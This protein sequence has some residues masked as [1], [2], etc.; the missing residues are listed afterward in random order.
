[1]CILLSLNAVQRSDD[2]LLNFS[3]CCSIVCN[4]FVIVLAEMC[5]GIHYQV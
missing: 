3:M 5:T 2:T 4:S 1:M